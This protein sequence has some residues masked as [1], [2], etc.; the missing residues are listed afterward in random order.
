MIDDR[1][2]HARVDAALDRRADPLDDPLV[3]ERLA[4]DP[5]LL[6]QFVLQRESLRALAASPPAAGRRRRVATVLV[7]TCLAAAGLCVAALTAAALGLAGTETAPEPARTPRILS[8]Q[9]EREPAP[10]R[11]IAT[12]TVH[13]SLVRT[14]AASFETYQQQS[15]PR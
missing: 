3:R 1:Q 2:F 12:F 9:L 11:P 15:L 7:T 14:A 4:A 6:E 8:V 5:E 10:M 13:E